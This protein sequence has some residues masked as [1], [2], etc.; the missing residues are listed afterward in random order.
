MRQAGLDHKT[1]DKLLANLEA[2][3]GDVRQADL[4]KVLDTAGEM[5]ADEAKNIL[6]SKGHVR[7]RNLIESI[8]IIR[9]RKGK[10]VPYTMVGPRYYGAYRGQIGHVLEFGT[11]ERYRFFG[12]KSLGLSS[13]K[14]KDQLL[15]KAST[16]RV[17]PS[18]FM[19]PAYQN[20]KG[21]VME[22]LKKE[23]STLVA[24]AIKKRGLT[25]TKA[26]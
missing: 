8:G 19:R 1:F 9:K 6:Q 20:K 14:V 26:A 16:G 2:I 4:S 12:N 15:G 22:Y 11:E 5:F 17:A 23:V 13:K 10:L 24:E 25:Y 18:P 7:T 3:P 21:A